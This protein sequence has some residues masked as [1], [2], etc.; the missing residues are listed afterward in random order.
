MMFRRL[1]GSMAA[2]CRPSP[3]LAHLQAGGGRTR[4]HA[5][6]NKPPLQGVLRLWSELLRAQPMA[7]SS[8]TTELAAAD[9]PRWA[10][11]EALIKDQL[12]AFQ[13]HVDGALLPEQVGRCTSSQGGGR[14]DALPRDAE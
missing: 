14:G 8:S 5:T 4:S 12:R 7:A 10:E 1:C 3:P 9:A 6:H 2:Y 13:G 11:A